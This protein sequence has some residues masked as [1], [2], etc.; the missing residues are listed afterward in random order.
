ADI[1]RAAPCPPTGAH[2]QRRDRECGTR[3]P[4][5]A[6]LMEAATA[7]GAIP[8]LA[9]V[10]AGGRVRE[11]TDA[12]RATYGH[13]LLPVEQA[14]VLQRVLDGQLARVRIDLN[15]LDA[16][17]EAATDARGARHALLSL[18]THDEGSPAGLPAGLLEGGLDE[19]PAMAYLKDADGR[20]LQINRR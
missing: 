6:G 3:A 14:E 19:S 8:A 16:T 13:A 18:A 2:A 11:R 12:F 9:L 7:A 4:R 17:I 15:G 5:S 10:G 1:R 20:Y